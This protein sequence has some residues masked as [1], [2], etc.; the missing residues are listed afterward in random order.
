VNLARLQDPDNLLDQMT[1]KTESHIR[2]FARVTK[3][4]IK[5][6]A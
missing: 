2:V 5:K 1:P 6:G 3:T 4:I